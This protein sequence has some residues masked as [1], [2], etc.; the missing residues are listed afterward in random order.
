M[1]LNPDCIRD[2]LLYLEE[3]LGY[4]DNKIS[5]EHKE[6]TIYRIIKDV[7]RDEIYL[8][9]DVKYSI[10]KLY[11]VGYIRL[12]NIQYDS[13]RYI[14][15]GNVND[16]TWEGHNFLNNIRPKSVWDATKEGAT[17]L[18]LMS[19]HALSTISMEVVKAVVTNPTVVNGIISS[20]NS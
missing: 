1:K 20:M 9:E 6:I 14:V 4:T 8:E 12:R 10:E 19:I 16:I 13:R 7:A 18:G 17:K 3:N 15:A 11:E 2:V 5:M